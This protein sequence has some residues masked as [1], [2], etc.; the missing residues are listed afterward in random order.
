MRFLTMQ[1]PVLA[2]AA[3]AA[4]LSASRLGL[5]LA[6]AVTVTGAQLMGGVLAQGRRNASVKAQGA[7]KK[8]S[9]RGIPK[10][11]GAKRTG[12]TLPP[13]HLTP[14]GGLNWPW[15]PLPTFDSP[16]HGGNEHEQTP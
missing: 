5:G 7:Y 16:V 14:C 11:L 12:G 4:S 8:K 9:K 3:S 2:A 6:A 10:K 1:R 15:N 13:Y